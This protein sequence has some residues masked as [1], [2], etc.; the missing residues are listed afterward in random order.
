[1]A[2]Y[3]DL[4]KET[5]VMLLSL[6]F[7]WL[8]AIV[9]TF[10]PT[11]LQAKNISGETVLV[12]GAGSGIGRLMAVRFAE[13]GCRLILWD[14]D[15]K[16][17]E[18]TAR[19]CKSVG[20]SAR[21]YTVDLSKRD[22]IYRVAS[23][24][25][26]DTGD[27]DILVNNAG[28]VTGKKFYI[29][30]APDNMIAKNI[31]SNTL[32]SKIYFWMCK[33]FLPGMMERNHGHIVNIASSA[34]LLGVNGL[35]DY[36]AS[37]FGAVGFDESLRFELEML[38]KDGVHT[39]AVCP[40]Y[41]STGMFEGCKTR[42]PWLLPILEPD[43][44]ANRIIDAVLCNQKVIILPRSLYFFMGLKGIIPTKVL[45]ILCLYFGA[46]NSMDEFKGRVV[47]QE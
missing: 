36:C 30:V 1:M 5:I 34:G 13:L 24:V 47:K 18:E 20:A 29:I 9:L 33:A 39:T 21:T 35:C 42:V 8:K 3:M 15:S 22:D 37:K 28:I 27:V 7:Y 2:D 41:I 45:S 14:I 12:T 46:S 11:S 23:Q 31:V 17:N 38:G 26:Q 32:D 19:Q 25:K 6:I 4:I 40:F 43:F 10:V 44:A 16:G